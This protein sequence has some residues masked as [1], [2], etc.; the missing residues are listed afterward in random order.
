M[1]KPGGIVNV[2]VPYRASIFDNRYRILK[3][4][5]L[6][7]RSF[8]VYLHKKYLYLPVVRTISHSHWGGAAYYVSLSRFLQAFSGKT[9]LISVEHTNLGSTFIR[10]K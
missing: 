7:Q 4:F 1:T 3:R 5:N 10:A 6:S 9:L 8:W 2:Q